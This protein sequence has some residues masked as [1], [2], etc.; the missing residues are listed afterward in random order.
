MSG[1]STQIV[2]GYDSVLLIPT[3]S[4]ILVVQ[5]TAMVESKKGDEAPMQRHTVSSS[6]IA[7]VGWENNTMEV[8][9]H[10]GTVYQYRGVS[11]SEY[12][13]FLNSPSL[14]S[15]LSRLDKEHPG[16]RV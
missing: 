1:T 7:S 14:G 5:A 11:S 16:R 8:Q 3:V 13:N 2:F 9:F 12:K 6:R 4:L 10:D 15:A